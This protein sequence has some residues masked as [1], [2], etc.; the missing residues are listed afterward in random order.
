MQTKTG[1]DLKA[2]EITKENYLV[3][4]GEELLYHI[5]QEQKQ[6]DQKT[7]KK[8]SRARIQKFGEKEWQT[9]VEKN[10]KKQDYNIEILHDPTEFKAINEAKA[11]EAKAAEEIEKAK[12]A[13][14][15]AQAE[16]EARQKEINDAVAKALANANKTTKTPKE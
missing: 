5:K 14:A 12:A 10:M 15:K 1:R 13:E 11:A 2:E 9:V 4:K 3:P 7:G 8:I 6:F 16:A